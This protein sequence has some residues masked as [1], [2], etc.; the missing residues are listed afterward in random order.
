MSMKI[1]FN[2]IYSSNISTK[3]NK[4]NASNPQQNSKTQNLNGLECISGYNIHFCAKTP[5]YIINYDGSYEKFESQA[6]AGKK[7]G[8]FTIRSCLD[9]KIYASGS[10]ILVYADEFENPD[11]E[12]NTSAINKI[13]L[14]FKY[15]SKQ[16]LYSIDFS[17]NIQ[18]YDSVKEATEK[19][20]ISQSEISNIL[21]GKSEISKGYTFAK[22]FDIESRD[23]NGKLMLDEN[24]KPIVDIKKLN[25]ARE[26]FLKTKKNF[27]IV[28][29]NKNGEIKLYQNSKEIADE[30]GT[31]KNNIIDAV[32][33]DN[34]V[35]N[36]YI[37]MRLSDI[38]EIDEFGNIMYDENNDYKLDEAKIRNIIRDRFDIN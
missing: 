37:F 33:N 35:S 27:P 34:V 31:T 38:V 7:H 19:T 2:P 8:G 16:P 15:A 6:E 14:N 18:R 25:K 23:E 9:G 26:N 10:K 12:V 5:V 32:Y 17:G 22:A 1:T 3:Q 13:L 30:L 24:D 29:I 4:I 28:S 11:K 20:G 21:S 36:N